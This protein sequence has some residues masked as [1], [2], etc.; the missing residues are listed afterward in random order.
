MTKRALSFAALTVF[1]TL[2]FVH[3]VGAQTTADEPGDCGTYEGVVCYGWFS[4]NANVAD[5]DEAIEEAIGALVGRY[6]NQIAV[7]TVTASPSG[8]PLEFANALGNAWGVGDAERQ[9]GIVV[10]VDIDNRR[11]E[12]TTG[13]GVPE[14]DYTRVTGAGNS[15]FGR[16]DFDSGII[17]IIGSLE[18][19]L[20]FAEGGTGDPDATSSNPG[21][22]LNPPDDESPGAGVVVGAIAVAAL[23]GGGVGL[24]AARQRRRDR[25]GKERAELVDGDVTAL[26]PAGHELPLLADYA[27]AFRGTAPDINTRAALGALER[28][29]GGVAPEHEEAVAALWSHDLVTVVERDRLNAE[30]EIPLELRVSAEQPLLEGALQAAIRNALEVDLDNKDEF[31]VRRQ[32]LQRIIA[33]LR[34]HRIANTRFR[35][36]QAIDDRS[37]RTALGFALITDAGARVLE[38]GAGLRPRGTS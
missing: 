37:V 33:S 19:E 16:D 34:P 8:T 22:S 12:M 32:E 18:Q 31:A 36:G 28:I 20:A 24:A 38:A 26:D 14:L 13:P 29:D 3:P 35:M 15:F 11:T 23:V 17:A 4:D 1:A 25:L 6:G 2:L 7:V 9:D 30:T 5:D 21:V 10:L 27:I